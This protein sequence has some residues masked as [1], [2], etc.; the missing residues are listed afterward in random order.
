MGKTTSTVEIE[1]KQIDLTSERKLVFDDP[2]ITKAEMIAYYRA[3]APWMVPHLAGRPLTLQC[4][5]GGIGKH[6]FY[7]KQA[8]DHFPDWISRVSLASKDGEMT[9]Y[10]VAN[11]AATLVFL[12]NYN[13]I[14]FHVCSVRPPRLDR[15]DLIIIDFDPADDDFAKV[16]EGALALRPMLTELGLTPF[17]KTSGS[18]GLH[19]VAPITASDDHDAVRH[20]A[21]GLAER[22]V[23]MIPEH[24]T[25]E[26][27]K[28]RR[29]DRVYV[30]YQ[31]NGQAQTV[32]A[33]Y[34]L[35]A[36]PGA[37]VA[38]PLRW[39]ELE[40]GTVHARSFTL[41]TVVDRLQRLGDP[42]RDMMASA[43]PLPE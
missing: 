11:D 21:R 30:D 3:V 27:N 13:S 26:I 15:P 39:D 25:I 4:F 18:R 22:L 34:S 7:Q 40:A 41:H 24:F 43:Q 31:C 29:G 16:R 17:V 8:P 37:P 2:A 32:A 35:R 6:W 5:P 14:A 12:A 28:Q 1:G 19:V 23:R 10:A 20:V 38:T 33:P 36:R 42:W 9:D